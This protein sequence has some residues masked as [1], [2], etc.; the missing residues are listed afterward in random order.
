MNWTLLLN[1]LWV[2]LLTTAVAV[3]LGLAAA[4]F[5][6]G[7]NPGLRW[8]ALIVAAIAFALPPFLV[9][10]TWLSLLGQTGWLRRWLP[11]NL[12]SL[13]GTVWLLALL[14]WPVTMFAALG[15][16]QRLEASQVESDPALAGFAFVRWLL[17]PAARPALVQAAVL[18]VVLALNNFA[19]PAVLQVKVL[20]VEVYLRVNTNLDYAGALIVSWPLI[21]GPLALLVWLTRREMTWPRLEGTVAPALFRLSLGSVL[22]WA[23]GVVAVATG[24]L[25][26]LLPLAQLLGTPR[27]WAELW[28]TA[29]AAQNACAMS[30]LTSA[31][32]AALAVLIGLVSWRLPAG[33][34]TWVLLLVPGVVLG[35][36][37]IR[38]LN[39]PPFLAFYRSTGIVLLALTCRYLAVGWNGAAFARR[40]V[41]RD[42]VDTARLSGASRWQLLRH[43]LWPQMC[44]PLAAAAYVVYLLCLWDVE[45]LVLIVPPGGETLALRIF[46]LLHYGH[47]PQINAL[48]LLLLGLAALPPLAWL[49]LRALGSAIA[50][51]R[52]CQS[53]AAAAALATAGALFLA[54]GCSPPPSSGA[55]LSSRLFSR[56]EII[57]TLGTAPG[58]FNKPRSVA[59]DRQ[60]N[61]YVVDM[62]G[63]VQK[64]SPHGTWLLSWQ[65]PETDLG[66]PKGM[67]LDGEGRVMVVEPHYSRL[68]HFTPDGKRWRQ[69]GDRGTNAGRLSFP[70]AVVCNP[71]GELFVSEYGAVDR[72]QRFSA[73]GSR[74][75]SSLGRFGSGPGEFNR[76][77]G[78]G[79][80][81]QDRLYVADSCNHRIQVF[82]PD[83][84]W[85]R[86]H[87]RAGQGVGEL[88]YPYD[89]RVDAAGNQFVCEFGGSRVQ[90]FDA[91]DAP[92][93]VLGQP[94]GA[95][96][97]FSNPW[98]LALDSAGNLYVADAGNHRVQKFIRRR[99]LVAAH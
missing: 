94:G 83:G 45:T 11:L 33:V 57:G 86:S 62:T 47:N 48:C 51:R 8:C 78:L 85:L 26:V 2:S 93:E 17:L 96:G 70:R 15:A 72:V 1:S 60:D 42:L 61:L 69:W 16:W 97:R 19:V 95:P 76:A 75:L 59:V 67:G 88:S 30:A 40:A 13:G 29:A 65:M 27:T 64:F 28:P 18:T 68:N 36:L 53:S 99:P 92:V 71:A 80:D 49:A 20:P 84:R 98:S 34:L 50:R 7:L 74:W 41:D 21:V 54:A 39:R 14:F 43:V 5:V 90:V 6:A 56:V 91:N 25:S 77:E 87:G 44:A 12:A 58:Q 38:L 55:A 79:I 52:W 4:L 73:D 31:A 82:G 66:R 23:C 10:N 3:G 37:L 89:V 9:T 22:F 81:A 63:R 24:A 35:I 32:S 46:S